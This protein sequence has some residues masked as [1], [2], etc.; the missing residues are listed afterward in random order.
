MTPNPP[1]VTRPNEPVPESTDPRRDLFF[2]VRAIAFLGL[3]AFLLWLAGDVLLLL[4]AGV[5]V[6]IFIGGIAGWIRTRTKMGRGLSIAVTLIGLT[7]LCGVVAFV[8]APDISEQ[9]DQ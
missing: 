4:F 6:A 5:L 2:I 7:L 3:I 9:V 8:S 1:L